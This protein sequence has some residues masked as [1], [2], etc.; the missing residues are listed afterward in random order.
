MSNMSFRMMS[1]IHDNP[2]RRL[3]DSPENTLR[4]AGVQAGQTILE[5]GPG[6]GFFTAPAARMA[7]A[8]GFLYAVDIHP[9]AIRMVED[10]VAKSGLTN[11]RVLQAD[12]AN[13]GLPDGSIDIALLFGVVATLPL[14]RVLL[15]L[16]RVLKDGGTVA[17]QAFPN[18]PVDRVTTGGTFA[19]LGRR[20][21]L[22]L[23]EKHAKGGNHA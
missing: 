10:K 18:W 8:R 16:N 13:T 15:E 23:F 17:I 6:P 5:V 12:A 1:V 7:G 14:D 2:L 9:L 21:G 22:Y 4:A 19:Y 3:I 20:R 11:V